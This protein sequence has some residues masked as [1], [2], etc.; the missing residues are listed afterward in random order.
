MLAGSFKAIEE[1]SNTTKKI[2]GSAS[3]KSKWGE[4][5]IQHSLKHQTLYQAMMFPDHFP[6]HW[7]AM[8]HAR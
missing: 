3:P 7:P 4:K 6:L 2:S 8:L 5:I 1:S